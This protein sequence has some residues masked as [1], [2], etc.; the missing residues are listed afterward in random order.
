MVGSKG[1]HDDRA[2][3]ILHSFSVPVVY[4]SDLSGACIGGASGCVSN[5]EL[6]SSESFN[7]NS[8]DPRLVNVLSSLQNNGTVNINVNFNK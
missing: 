4:A 3:Q 6:Q 7:L 1:V 8:I 2:E 5:T